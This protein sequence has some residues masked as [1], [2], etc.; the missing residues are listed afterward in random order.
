MKP[1]LIFILTSLLIN[2]SY[3][4][5]INSN[6]T[7]RKNVPLT[8]NNKSTASINNNSNETEEKDMPSTSHQ[9]SYSSSTSAHTAPA[10]SPDKVILN[11][12]NADISSVIKAIGQLSGKNF[13]VDP[14][15]K[16]SITII[17]T[18]P[19][20]KA[21]SYKV[22]ESALRMQ[23]FATVEAD[24]VIKVLPETDAKTYGMKTFNNTQP[25]MGRKNPGDQIVTKVFVLQHGSAMQMSNSLRPLIA[26]N[27]SISVYPSSN[28][29]VI[30][31]YSSNIARITKII[32]QL[33]SP[34][35]AMQSVLI[36]FKHA[37]AADV[38]Q[39]L[40][41]FLQGGG[42]SGYGGGG[43]GGP[44]DGP[45]VT[46]NTQVQ[47]NSILLYSSSRAKLNELQN[48]ALNMDKTIGDNHND[49][50]VVY[51]KNADATHIAEVLRVVATGQE[52]PDLTAT[53]TSTKFTNEPSGIFSTGGSGGS[54]G[55]S[56][57][58][59]GSKGGG[60]QQGGG[61]RPGGAGA[62]NAQKDQPKVF[63]QAETTTNSLIIQAPEAL[64]RN[65]RMI[66]DMLDVRRAQ[67][68]IEAMIADISAQNSGTFGIQWVAGGGANNAGVIG[69]GNYGD[70]GSALSDLATTALGIQG[71]ASGNGTGSPGGISIPK[72]V[73]IG[74]VTGT[75]TIGGQTIPSLST[76]A[77]M[78]SA[79]SSGNILS[80]PTLITLDNEEA[81]IQV[82]ANV[83]IPNGSFTASSGS[84][85]N[86]TTTI[87]RQDL[88]TFLQIKP[89]ITQSGS[90]QLDI[91]QEDS[92]LDPNI[93]PNSPS[94]PSFLKRTMRSTILLDDSQIIALGG[95]TTDS[96]SLQQNGIPILSSIPW[97]GW[98]FSWQHR[99]HRKSNLVLFLRPVIIRNAEG[100][101]AL[102]NQRYQ[103]VMDQE[104]KIQAS[105]NLLLP[106]I[107]PVTLDNQVPYD[108]LV[109]TQKATQP[110]TPLVDVRASTIANKVNTGDLPSKNSS[111]TG[112]N[113]STLTGD[114]DPVTVTNVNR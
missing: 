90:I 85:G 112:A 104:N 84:P 68:M 113:V 94:G 53:P 36:P 28:A 25:T 62:N 73:Y 110:A 42:G 48:I 103:Y 47:T 81:R 45:S 65:L 41:N 29:L 75:T 59:S 111:S 6:S 92:Q 44:T 106:D 99:E 102:S 105:G 100:Y 30:T 16:G 80:R 10:L 52:N 8:K 19:V 4:A 67:V 9:S 37:I 98:L 33:S 74:L 78:I 95:M 96:I 72:E 83:G 55:G 13:V 32:N 66:I 82:G 93:L 50:H 79:T 31:D 11:F 71:A 109:P 114:T 40:Q 46:I 24:G 35:V 17:S 58:Y 97:I 108:N 61:Y 77:D 57:A 2:S 60:Y 54:G 20:S 56:S 43:G 12:E 70:R 101:K 1:K 107:K 49:L 18:S 69:A 64:Y 23:G 7:D 89:K 34:N 3:S 22:L 26:P 88:G 87:T 5:T 27:N 21:E 76:L 14:R 63:V 15:V 86:L 51:L 38:A 91:Y 39:V